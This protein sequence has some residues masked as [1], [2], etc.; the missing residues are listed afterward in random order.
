MERPGSKELASIKAIKLP[1]LPGIAMKIIEVMQRESPSIKEIAEMISCDPSLSAKILQTV[2]S[3]FYGLPTKIGG[4]SQAIALIGLNSVKNLA[5]GFSLIKTFKP[6]KRGSFDHIQFWKDSITGAIASKTIADRVNRN[7]ADDAFFL[8]LLQNIGSL[9]MAES[10]PEKYGTVIGRMKAESTPLH[11]AEYDEFGF[12]HMGVG[13]YASKFWNLPDSISLPIG[14]HHCPQR[15]K[16][17][18]EKI[19]CLA[20]ILHLSSLYIDIFGFMKLDGH[21]SLINGLIDKYGYSRKLDQT[22]ILQE[23]GEATKVIFPI[24]EIAVDERQHAQ[25]IKA[26]KNELSQLTTS[27][28]EQIHTQEKSLQTLKNQ[29]VRDSM[30]QLYNH[31]HFVQLLREELNRATRYKTPLSLILADI[32]HFKSVNDFYGHLAGDFVL[33]HIALNLQSLSR[34]SDHIARYGGEEFAIILTSTSLDGAQL[35]GERLR[36]A[37][38]STKI[39]YNGKSICVT[40]SFGIVSLENNLRP[41]VEGLIKM[42]D[43][44]LYEAKNSGRNKCC[45][46]QEIIPD[47]S[48]HSVLVV[49]DEEALLITVTKMLSR[50]GYDAKSARNGQEAID[51]F[52]INHERI[53]T[54][55]LD[56]VMPGMST[57]EILKTIKKLRPGTRV[58]LASGLSIDEI[59]KDLI[60]ESDG[61]LSKP[62]IMSDLSQAIARNPKKSYL[63]SGIDEG[64]VV[65]KAS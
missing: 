29:V 44:A 3:P 13:E 42:A 37:I 64:A 8:G 11:Q 61:F 50:L 22:T 25:I 20:T 45:C 9:I 47:H 5:L 52:S 55:L 43:E 12:D 63:K 53:D 23:I 33:K 18:S 35:F 34:E 65:L 7:I 58:L 14:S 16:S 51:H 10:W 26:A 32:D 36:K 56:V 60:K 49:D 4:V 54:V 17:S 39:N 48:L 19:E 27:L 1:T 46:Y 24:F 59:E 31:E 38:S 15:I 57:Q 62:F 41:D 28:I 40:M 6:K 21:G 30:T 2:N